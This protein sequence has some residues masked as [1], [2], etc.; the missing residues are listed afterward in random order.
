MRKAKKI[1]R[2]I[3][4]LGDAVERRLQTGIA[5]VTRSV[6]N[7]SSRH[8]LYDALRRKDFDAALKAVPWESVGDTLLTRRM[9][10]DTVRA[11]LSASKIAAN[12][13]P[14]AEPYVVVS[15]AARDWFQAKGLARV[16]EMS[17]Q[18]VEGLRRAMVYASDQGMNLNQTA[19]FILPTV[20]LRSDQV[21]AL[22]RYREGLLDAGEL[23]EDVP[24]LVAERA[25]EMRIQ[26]GKTIART[27]SMFAIHGGVRETWADMLDRGVLQTEDEVQ[28][29][30]SQD[31]ETCDI[32]EPMDL[33][34]RA[35][36][37]DGWEN[38][39]GEALVD[40]SGVPVDDPPAHPNC[41]CTTELLLK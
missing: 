4:A 30:T 3:H 27:E 13:V 31:E 10:A 7:R 40:Y 20:S 35:V 22:A 5:G 19:E 16:T 18:A 24:S 39:D 41:R 29:Y 9:K 2:R 25:R 17:K 8:K 15:N 14:T 26:R 34:T 38:R 33:Q 21:D 28:W 36:D 32:C 23:E 12:A 37:E 11:Y 6:V 1:T